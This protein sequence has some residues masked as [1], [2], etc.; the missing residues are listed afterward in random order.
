M[1]NEA[2]PAEIVGPDDLGR[3]FSIA[4]G[5]EAQPA[6]IVRPDDLGWLLLIDH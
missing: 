5:K 2:Q 3:C 6:E 1:V 4:N